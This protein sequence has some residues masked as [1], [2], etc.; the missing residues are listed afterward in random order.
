MTGGSETRQFP[1]IEDHIAFVAAGS[2]PGARYGTTGI[3]TGAMPAWKGS[4]TEAQIRAVVEYE[5]T[6]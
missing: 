5:R 4:L 3:G 6:L 1:N 2:S